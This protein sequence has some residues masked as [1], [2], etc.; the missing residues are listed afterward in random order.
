LSNPQE[1]KKQP[2]TDTI[3]VFNLGLFI[4]D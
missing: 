1:T 3:F 4:K 2:A